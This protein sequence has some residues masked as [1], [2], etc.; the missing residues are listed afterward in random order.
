M[1]QPAAN[2][3]DQREALSTRL[4]ASRDR[5]LR[6][7]TDV[8]ENLVRLSSGE[9]SWS[10]LECAEHI[11]LAER[12]MFSSLERRRATG[13]PPDRSRDALIVTV[14]LDRTRK[15]PVP[16]RVRPIGQF[17]TLSE[18]VSDFCSARE[19]TL[20]FVQHANEDLRLSTAKHPFGLFDSYQFV[21]IMALH[22]ERHALQ[23]EEIKQS[24][25]YREAQSKQLSHS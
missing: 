20:N 5:V 15:V 22:A 2:I 9:G 21:L 3:L 14:A 24:S 17:S 16:D 18:A 1:P 11:A 6:V 25:A 13:V 19:R 7:L 23:I 10:I 8:P 4:W 12:G